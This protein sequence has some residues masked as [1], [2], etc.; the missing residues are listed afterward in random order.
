MP[1]G[2]PTVS[3]PSYSR[4]PSAIRRVPQRPRRSVVHGVQADRRIRPVVIDQEM[5]RGVLIRERKRSDRSCEPLVLLLV[6]AD[7][8]ARVDSSMWETVVGAVGAAK[9]DTDVLGWFGSRSTLGILLTEVQATSPAIADQLDARIRRELGKRLGADSAGSF[10]IRLH[11]YPEPKVAGA[12]G[13][14]PVEPLLDSIRRPDGPTTTLRDGI[15]RGL[16]VIGSLTLL[17]LLSPLLLLLA[18][19]VRL[20]SPGPV[21]FRQV[22][23]GE[24]AKPFTMLKFRTMHVNA[25]HA[26]HQAFVTGLI[27]A[28]APTGGQETKGLFKIVNDPRVTPLGR[29]LR[30]TSLDELP[31]LWNVLRGDMSLVGPRPPLPYEVEQYKPWHRRRV[32]DAKP[33]ITGLWQVTGRSRTTF[34]DMVRLDLRY[35]KTRSLWTDCK[36][37]LATP[38]A[39]VAGKGAC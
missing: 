39:V 5:F 9:R 11:V 38:M 21:L 22:R 12:N 25:D 13:L 30:K 4:V 10:S 23:I 8:R 7:D 28:T 19:L 15:K 27:N 35:A 6:G 24:R 29:I 33:G 2:L 16:D 1:S 20:K 31:Q 32:L 36:I 37:L 3:A 18:W 26:I 17:T 34:D 14:W